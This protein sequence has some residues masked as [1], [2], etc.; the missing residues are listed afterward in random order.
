VNASE[1][2]ESKGALAAWSKGRDYDPRGAFIRTPFAE[3][4][5]QMFRDAYEVGFERAMKI[6]TVAGGRQ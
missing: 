6:I 3:S 4:E 5:W 1:S 2:G